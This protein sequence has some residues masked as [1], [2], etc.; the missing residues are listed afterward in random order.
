MRGTR[1]HTRLEH[2][3]AVVRVRP[4]PNGHP[5]QR[6]RRAVSSASLCVRKLG[7]RLYSIVRVAANTFRNPEGSGPIF[8][9]LQLD[10]QFSNTNRFGWRAGDSDYYTANCV[11]IRRRILHRRYKRRSPSSAGVLAPTPTL[12]VL[13]VHNDGLRH[14]HETNQTA[15]LSRQ[16]G[17]VPVKWSVRKRGMRHTAS[18][19]AR[20]PS[21][22][23]AL[24]VHPPPTELSLSTPVRDSLFFSPTYVRTSQ[25]ERCEP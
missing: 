24:P 18:A 16:M 8:S 6:V 1:V 7:G 17:R 21:S 19:T 3:P 25:V 15:A 12:P 22:Q 10:D 14:F 13:W 5:Q 20:T 11:V 2:F 9:I 4:R 23:M